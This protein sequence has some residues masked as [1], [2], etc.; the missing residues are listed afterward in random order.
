VRCTKR[1]IFAGVFTA[2]RTW[3]WPDRSD[4][5]AGLGAQ[6][7]SG[8]QTINTGGATQLVVGRGAPY[9]TEL[10][11]FDRSYAGQTQLMVSNQTN[12]AASEAVV[13]LAASGGDWYLTHGST[14]K[15]GNTF[16]IRYATTDLVTIDTNGNLGVGVTPTGGNGLLQLA[17]GTTRAN[18]IAAGTDTFLWRNA[19]NSWTTEGAFLSIG[20][21]S[22]IG[23]AVGA[24]GAVTQITSRT[25]GVTINKVSGAITLVSAAGS[26]TYQTFT[27]T[28]SA[29][30]ATDTI[31]VNQKSGTD[32]HIIQVTNIAAGSFAITFA[33][34][35]GT[36]T[37]QPVFNFAII[38][39]AAT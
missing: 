21:T 8:T 29:V 25:T 37:E 23:Y 13:R 16:T 33:T 3:T 32:K 31:I 18:G 38:K 11:L 2:T 22:G 30:A 34:T 24:G 36:T 26:A 6:T 7:F 15:N 14:A 9:A 1:L 27:V 19:A 17:S 35:G 10:A 12:N 28:N 20:P 4:T 5:V 39:A